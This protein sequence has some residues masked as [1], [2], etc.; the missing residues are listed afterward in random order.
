MYIVEDSEAGMS[1]AKKMAGS[2]S[3][4]SIIP[5]TSEEMEVLNRGGFQTISN[6]RSPFVKIDPDSKYIFF[7]AV[8]STQSTIDDVLSCSRH[9]GVEIGIIRVNR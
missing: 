8:N 9:L 4:S 3:E 1:L 2:K 6:E 5:L 7:A